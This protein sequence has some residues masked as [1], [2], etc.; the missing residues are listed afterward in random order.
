MNEVYLVAGILLI[1]WGLVEGLWTTLWID[2]NSA[3]VTSR[4]TTFIWKIFRLIFRSQRDRKLSLA[5]PTIL[6]LT[7]LMWIV[8]IWLGWTLIFYSAPNSLE[9]GSGTLPVDFTDVLWYTS[10]NMFTVGN[11]DFIPGNDGWQI[12]SSFISLSGMT[13]VTLS[14]TYVLQVI[15]A[16]AVKRS[17]AGQITGIGKSAEEFVSKQWT[18]EGFGA[19]ELQL[20]SLSQ[21]LAANNEQHLAYPILH[22]YHAARIEKSQDVA[23]AILDDAL[24]LIEHGVEE[25]YKPAETILSSARQSVSSFLTT[26]RTAFIKAADEVPPLPDIGLLRKNGIP[27]IS[28]KEFTDN[29]KKEDERRKLILGLLNNGAWKWPVSDKL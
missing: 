18:G 8:C 19:I 13:M 4:F 5:G 3:P 12:I 26:L 15:S 22:Y 23:I 10:Y 9:A 25:R 20:N 2:G 24:T 16:V 1:L 6:L 14:I 11:G 17:I 27:A 29:I 7:V 28:D 21:Q